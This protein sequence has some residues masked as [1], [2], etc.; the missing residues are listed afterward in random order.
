MAFRSLDDIRFLSS[1]FFL[2]SFFPI[3][4]FVV[5]LLRIFCSDS[6]MHVFGGACS[7]NKVL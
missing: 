4:E 3:P 6:E 5:G 2:V 7:A 1:L